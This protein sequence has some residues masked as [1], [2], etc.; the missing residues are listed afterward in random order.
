MPE[1]GYLGPEGTFSQEALEIF[2]KDKPD[3]KS[4]A[5]LAMPDILHAVEDRK[6]D[7]AFVPIENSIEGPVNEILDMLAF[8]VDLMIKGEVIVPVRQ[9]L[10]AKKGTL[11][12]DIGTILSHPQ[13][14]GQCRRYLSSYFPEA[15]VKLVPSTA[16]AAKEVAAGG[17]GLAAIG[18]SVAARLYGLEVLRRDVQDN[19]S[20]TTRFVAISRNDS[21]RTGNDKTSIVFSAEDR[22]GSLYSVLEIFNIWDINLT[23]IESRPAK[24]KLGK[25]IFFV[26]MNGHRDDGDIRDALRMVMRKT[27]FYK[28][29]GSYRISDTVV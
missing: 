10:L 14:I 5:F 20:N 21:E 16:A 17:A 9:N 4:R 19:D 12:S 26:D 23:K 28:L 1:I 7:E 18:S 11:V 24:N 29:L 15:A 22:P 6:V 2:I 13:G 25:Y 8:D 27:S 3:Y